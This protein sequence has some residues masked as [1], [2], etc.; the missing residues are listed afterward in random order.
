MLAETVYFCQ[1]IIGVL[2]VDKGLTALDV[3]KRIVIKG[4][5]CTVKGEENVSAPIV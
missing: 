5:G 2:S 4:N 1:A 3:Q